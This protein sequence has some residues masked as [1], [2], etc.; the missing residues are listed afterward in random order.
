MR[1][2]IP[3]LTP[4]EQAAFEDA[5]FAAWMA[6]V[7]ALVSREVCGLTTADLPDWTWRDSFDAGEA[8]ADAAS[9]FMADVLPE[10]EP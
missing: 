10:F 7:D 5:A 9:E 3:M 1:A 8:P 4:A 2:T 6:R